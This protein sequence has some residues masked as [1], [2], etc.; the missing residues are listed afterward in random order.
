MCVDRRYG[1]SVCV[2]A[3]HLHVQ[4]ASDICAVLVGDFAFVEV[5]FYADFNTAH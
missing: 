5:H 2:V 1:L 4:Q 3:A